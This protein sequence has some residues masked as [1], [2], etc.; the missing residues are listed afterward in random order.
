MHGTTL[1]ELWLAFIPPLKGVGIPAH[2]RISL[3][4]AEDFKSLGYKVYLIATGWKDLF[5]GKRIVAYKTNQV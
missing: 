5:F 3:W 2:L 1:K 4:T